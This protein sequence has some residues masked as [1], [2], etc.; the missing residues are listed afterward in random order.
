MEEDDTVHNGLTD[1]DQVSKPAAEDAEPSQRIVRA[2]C[3]CPA[4]EHGFQPTSPQIIGQA[5]MEF[6]NWMLADPVKLALAQAELML[7][8]SWRERNYVKVRLSN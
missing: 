2:F 6:G 7:G 4:E 5:F 1:P 8:W 3:E